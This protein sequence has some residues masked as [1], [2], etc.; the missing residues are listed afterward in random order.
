MPPKN[1]FEELK[2]EYRRLKKACIEQEEALARQWIFLYN[3]GGE[4]VWNTILDTSKGLGKSLLRLLFGKKQR[5][6]VLT[7]F[8]FSVAQ[9][10][11]IKKVNDW[12]KRKSRVQET[13]A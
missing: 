3:H 2:M 13:A 6:S 4:L 7:Q 9:L 12:R 10:L 5:S 11:I 1:A 8:I